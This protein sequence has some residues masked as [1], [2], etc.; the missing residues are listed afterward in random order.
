[1]YKYNVLLIL[2]TM[3]NEGKIY[4]QNSTNGNYVKMQTITLSTISE[5]LDELKKNPKILDNVCKCL[6]SEDEVKILACECIEEMVENFI[7]VD[8]DDEGENTEKEKDKESLG[9]WSY[10]GTNYNELLEQVL[11][12]S[13]DIECTAI[14]VFN[15]LIRIAK[16]EK[17][18]KN[19]FIDL[20]TT[21]PFNFH[22]M[23]QVRL[24]FTLMMRQ[25]TSLEFEQYQTS[26]RLRFLSIE[27]LQ[28]LF[29]MGIQ[30]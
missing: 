16:H 3:L 30:V 2:K 6:K 10:Q 20:S 22:K 5:I 12:D 28:K 7:Q 19:K 29:L 15:L 25:I 1:M 4:L 23:L 8:S 17:F 18:D 26:K 21:L 13:D 27:L 24:S 11:K 14:S 9:H